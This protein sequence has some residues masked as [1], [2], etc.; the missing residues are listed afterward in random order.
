[1]QKFLQIIMGRFAIDFLF[2]IPKRFKFGPLI[3]K[4]FIDFLRYFLN[5]RTCFDRDIGM[6]PV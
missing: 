1:M 4:I 3:T 5:F 2:A 6:A